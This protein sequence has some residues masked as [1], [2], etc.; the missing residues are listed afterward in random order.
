[1]KRISIII[2]VPDDVEV[3]VKEPAKVEWLPNPPTD[4]SLMDV[5][6]KITSRVPPVK[7]GKHIDEVMTA[8][9]QAYLAGPKRG[10]GEQT[11]NAIKRRFGL[12]TG[13]STGSLDATHAY[14]HGN[15]FVHGGELKDGGQRRRRDCHYNTTGEPRCKSCSRCMTW[16]AIFHHIN[17]HRCT[18]GDEANIDR[19][20]DAIMQRYP[21]RVA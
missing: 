4:T 10:R 14:I 1:M 18:S 15:V 20:T 12:P 6:N 3:V 13:R 16:W 11:I 2:E 9:R 8:C 21:A 7:N 17:V 19:L 5:V